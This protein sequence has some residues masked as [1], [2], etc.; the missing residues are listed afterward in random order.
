CVANRTEEC[1]ERLIVA[2]KRLHSTWGPKKI[3]DVLW[4]KHGLKSRPA[5]STVGEVLKRHGL[6]KTRKRRGGLFTVERSTPTTAE[7][8]NHV[9]GVDFKGSFMLGDGERCDP[10]T[11]SDLFS[12]FVMKVEAMPDM[13]VKWTKR[14]FQC[15][16]RRYGLPEIIRVDNGSPF[17][18]MGPG[19]LS[20]LSVWW[21]S[22]GIEVQFSRPGCP[23]DNGCHERMHR[24]MKAECCVPG[25]V[26][27]WAQQQRF[28]RWRKVFNEDRPHEALGM[29]RPAEVYQPS[30]KR[31]DERIKMEL[32]DAGVETR[33]VNSGGFISLKGNACY[34]GE[35]FVGV[36]VAVE[37]NP[38]T[39]LLGVRFANVKL[40]WLEKG[41]KARLRPPAYAELWKSKLASESKAK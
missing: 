3:H 30:A 34:V 33:R 27:R 31:L 40:G 12:R 16:F 5:I 9:L 18:S 26:N 20:R 24:T 41:P 25:S 23:Q 6:V 28:D 13:T 4:V 1:V 2:E 32:Y 10:L 19:G 14:E 29:R 17:A 7:R 38:E 39:G 15:I 21:I 11:V 35:S 22:L 8:S 36:D 37:E